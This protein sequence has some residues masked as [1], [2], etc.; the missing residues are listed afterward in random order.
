MA[1]EPE[2]KKEE[3][4]PTVT[5]LCDRV[6]LT[7]KRAGFVA[8]IGPVPNKTGTQFG[9]ILDTKHTGDN[10]GTLNGVQYFKAPSKHGVF[11]TQDKIKKS[12]RMY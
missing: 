6:L 10:N 9:V 5:T 11:I 4:T 3:T 12:K 2:E 8:F 7:D 1:A